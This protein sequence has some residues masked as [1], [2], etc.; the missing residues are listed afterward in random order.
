MPD[1]YNDGPDDRKPKRGSDKKLWEMYAL[2]RRWQRSGVDYQ[3]VNKRIHSISRGKIA[4]IASLEKQLNV[5][6]DD[7]MTRLKGSLASVAEGATF[8]FAGEIA[9]AAAHLIPGGDS[10]TS[11]R[12][13]FESALRQ[14]RERSPGATLTGEMAGGLGAAIPMAATGIG[15]TSM[16]GGGLLGRTAGGAAQGGAMGGGMG[17]IYGAGAAEPGERGRGAVGGGVAGTAIGGTAGSL[18]PA[19]G[20]VGRR[21]GIAGLT[22]VSEMLGGEEGGRV[23]QRLGQQAQKLRFG[24]QAASM[25]QKEVQ[26]AL[27][28]AGVQPTPE[29]VDAAMR[30]K[31]SG[32][33]GVVADIDPVLG[34]QAGRAVATDPGLGAV[35]GPARK[36]EAR[37]L[38][39]G[40]RMSTLTRE[41]AEMPQRRD[42][43]ATILRDKRKWW[44]ANILSPIRDLSGDFGSMRMGKLFKDHPEIQRVY[45]MHPK[46]KA[47]FKPSQGTMEFGTA[48]DMLQDLSN[49]VK[50]GFKNPGAM[51]SSTLDDLTAARDAWREALGEVDGFTDAMQ[52]YRSFSA[53]H[54]G[55]VAGGKAMNKSSHVIAEDMR[56]LASEYGDDAAA[57]Y[58]EGLLDA[59][60]DK[61]IKRAGGGAT[62]KTLT[63]GGDDLEKMRVLFKPGPEGDAAFSMWQRSMAQEG[64]MELTSGFV[65]GRMPVL[66]ERDMRVGYITTKRAMMNQALADIIED[67]SIGAAAARLAGE[68]YLAPQPEAAGILGRLQGAAKDATL[69]GRVRNRALGAP[70]QALSRGLMPPREPDERDRIREERR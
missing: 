3:T 35:G 48:W 51:G 15:A 31:L 6:K 40:E 18:A 16:G 47:G 4:G 22:K 13:K 23:A 29:A 65:S 67:P 64:M 62:A 61:L 14:Q 9:G 55:R 32:A 2:A 52:M 20:A 19:V 44:R 34:R 58:R 26:D 25:A 8:G 66:S 42:G 69:L 54:A 39:R 59:L 46:S 21:A 30:G 41:A 12:E 27:R 11:Q 56:N 1:H 70:A 63:I 28:R 68:F 33:P 50:R 38:A 60:E 24:G 36:I 43:A 5:H 10:Y 57:F 7:R 53:E 17:A 45:R 49:Q 37:H